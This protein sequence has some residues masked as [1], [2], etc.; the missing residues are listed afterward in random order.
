MTHLPRVLVT[1]SRTWDDEAVIKD[2]LL[3]TYIHFGAFRLVHGTARGADRMAAKAARVLPGVK[4]EGHP[5]Q[6]NRHGHSAGF[7]RNKHMVDLGA[8]LCIAFIKD[9]SAGAT[10]CAGLAEAAGIKTYR[11][12]A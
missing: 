11:F 7:V 8:A 4:I 5:A 10:M 12:T 1:G 9:D 2:A 3:R 6:W